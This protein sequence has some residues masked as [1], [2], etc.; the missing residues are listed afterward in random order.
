MTVDEM[1]ASGADPS[2][3]EKLA[4]ELTCKI[5]AGNA[6]ELAKEPQEVCEPCREVSNP[7]LT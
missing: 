2:Q 3:A 4:A 1:I 6:A 5:P 7:S